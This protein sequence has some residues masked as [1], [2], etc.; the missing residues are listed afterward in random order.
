MTFWRIFLSLIT[1]N[2][3][4]P[5]NRPVWILK[6]NYI[7]L[8]NISLSIIFIY[9]KYVH[10]LHKPSSY[11]AGQLSLPVGWLKP[12]QVLKVLELSALSA[13]PNSRRSLLMGFVA[14]DGNPSGSNAENKENRTCD[15]LTRCIPFWWGV[16]NNYKSI[17]LLILA[18]RE[19]GHPTAITRVMSSGDGVFRLRGQ[20][21]TVST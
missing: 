16:C 6:F 4:L 3:S 17:K 20:C 1:N 13:A 11:L 5:C 14:I 9:V 12:G 19:S 18:S 21:P 7:N 8:F 2:C 10:G 15:H